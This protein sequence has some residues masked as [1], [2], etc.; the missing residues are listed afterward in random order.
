LNQK[1]R[2]EGEVRRKDEERKPAAAKTA[3]DFDAGALYVIVKPW[4]AV[5]LAADV[6]AA[7]G[8]WPADFLVR[9]LENPAVLTAAP[10]AR[11]HVHGGQAEVAVALGEGARNRAIRRRKTNERVISRAKNSWLVPLRD[12]MRHVADKQLAAALAAAR[13]Q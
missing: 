8:Q 5:C 2:N 4:K 3:A 11:I 9:W 13:R 6:T 12:I 1:P 10:H 7:R